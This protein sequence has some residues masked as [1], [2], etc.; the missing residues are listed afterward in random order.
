MRIAVVI[1]GAE[2][3]RERIF[4]PA[5]APSFRSEAGIIATRHLLL[6]R[7]PRLTMAAARPFMK[8]AQYSIGPV[9]KR[10]PAGAGGAMAE[11]R[12]LDACGMKVAL[13]GNYCGGHYGIPLGGRIDIAP[14]RP[15]VKG[16]SVPRQQETGWRDAAPLGDK[17]PPCT[18]A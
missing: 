17:R 12:G 13:D 1:R 11:G 9:L 5:H 8:R 16:S 18:A 14:R 7:G 4:P 10:D 2:L 15:I 6:L 3:N